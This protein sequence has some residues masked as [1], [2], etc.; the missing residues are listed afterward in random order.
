MGYG[1]LT[2][3][4]SKILQDHCIMLTLLLTYQ[5]NHFCTLLPIVKNLVDMVTTKNQH[6]INKFRKKE[7]KRKTLDEKRTYQFVSVD[8]QCPRRQ[9]QSIST[10]MKQHCLIRSQ[11]LMK[12]GGKVDEV[13]SQRLVRS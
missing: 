6:N 5:P 4:Q 11:C 1:C 8:G 7:I 2:T 3:I 12:Y 10:Q 13:R 9:P